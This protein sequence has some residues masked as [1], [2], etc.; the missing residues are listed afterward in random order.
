ME[1][2]MPSFYLDEVYKR[3]DQKI[4]DGVA[5]KYLKQD[6]E[7]KDAVTGIEWDDIRIDFRK[8]LIEVDNKVYCLPESVTK[9]FLF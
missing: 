3:I 7:N 1:E 8:G 4:S 6:V 9:A 2:K 5:F